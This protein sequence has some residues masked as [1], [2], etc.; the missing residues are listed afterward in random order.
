MR[1]ELPSVLQRVLDRST[2]EA[3]KALLSGLHDSHPAAA[4]ELAKAIDS[5]PHLEKMLDKAHRDGHLSSI[6]FTGERI[7]ARYRADDGSIHLNPRRIEDHLARPR[8]GTREALHDF[9]VTTLAH[10]ASHAL[11]SKGSARNIDQLHR[12]VR[13]SLK[14]ASHG[15]MA[16][17]T[18]AADRYLS[19]RRLSEARAEQAAYNALSSRIS[20]ASGE[21]PDAGTLA[22]RSVLASNCTDVLRGDG[23]RLAAGLSPDARGMIPDSQLEAVARCFYDNGPANLGKRGNVDYHHAYAGFVLRVAEH[24]KRAGGMEQVP[25]RLDFERLGL[26]PARVQDAGLDFGA[27]GRG[28]QV[29]DARGRKLRF[30]HDAGREVHGGHARS[31]DDA[32]GRMAGAADARWHDDPLHQHVRHALGARLPEGASMSDERMAQLTDAARQAGIRPG[33]PIELVAHGGDL[34][35]RGR[36]PTHVA[37]VDLDAVPEPHRADAQAMP[38]PMPVRDLHG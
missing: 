18:D 11:D 38:S 25:V 33:E 7:S 27:P 15:G 24:E 6:R 35:V 32:A 17:I 9:L 37:R 5:S 16:D 10:E 28:L 22:R 23:P 1:F 4:A 3:D 20:Q 29:H 8:E 31:G 14:Q 21:V 19:E 13:A 34:V 2:V 36:H 12:Q 30:I 26:D